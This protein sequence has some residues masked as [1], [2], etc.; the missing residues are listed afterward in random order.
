[1]LAAPQG[2]S[3]ALDHDRKEHLFEPPR[4]LWR[5]LRLRMEP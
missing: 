3:L 5:L 2:S 4:I 1:V